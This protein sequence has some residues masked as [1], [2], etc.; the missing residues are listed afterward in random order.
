[1]GAADG[2]AVVSARQ[3]PATAR[4]G[5]SGLET[6]LA[7]NQLP[8]KIRHILIGLAAAGPRSLHEDETLT[9]GD[10]RLL[11]RYFEV[12]AQS[13][14]NPGNAR[15]YLDLLFRGV[16]LTGKTMLDIGAGDGLNSLYA[17]CMG[18][19]NVVCLEPEA[20]GSSTGAVEAFERA[21]S[22]LEQ[23]QV[24][25][26]PQPLQ[27][28][29]AA[30]DSFDVLLLH[31]SINHLDEDA[32]IRLHSDPEAQTVYLELFDK[33]AAMAKPGA[34]LIAV[35]C[36]RRNL[37]ADLK[38]TNPIAPMIE[39]HKHQSPELW[40]SLL[41]RVGFANQTIRWLSF[42]T[43]RSYGRLVLGNRIASYCLTSVFL[44]TMEKT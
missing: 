36:A 43:L 40:A 11:D 18:A 17:A 3:T 15:F 16:D 5:P 32:C 23:K 4:T 13:G 21:A 12:V 33:L 41:A 9:Q 44:L 42:N 1:V 7:C 37:F 39:W 26:V 38:V 28:Y 27:D 29:E 8:S 10:S 19:S 2:D 25:F 14:R 34:R 35:D 30:D 6:S 24:Q 20:A 31:A 22:L